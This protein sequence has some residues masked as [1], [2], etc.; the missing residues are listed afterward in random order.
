M[1]KLNVLDEMNIC[2]FTIEAEHPDF[3]YSMSIFKKTAKREGRLSGMC[4]TD[5]QKPLRQK[6]SHKPHSNSEVY[7]LILIPVIIRNTT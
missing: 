7:N 4:R 1:N 3:T 2:I 6:R 5:S